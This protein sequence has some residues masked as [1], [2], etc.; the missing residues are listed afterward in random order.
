M[1]QITL[2]LLKLCHYIDYNMMVQMGFM[3]ANWDFDAFV[4]ITKHN[5]SKSI[6]TWWITP[7]N[8]LDQSVMR[9]CKSM[10]SCQKGPT[11]HAYTWQIGPF[12]QDTLEVWNYLPL[13]QCRSVFIARKQE[14]CRMQHKQW[15]CIVSKPIT[16]L[17][18]CDISNFYEI[19]MN[20]HIRYNYPMYP[21][22]FHVYYISIACVYPLPH[23]T[24]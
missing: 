23:L 16:F 1:C 3:I 24:I 13:I 22:D 7:C 6:W 17:H 14:K 9:L 8:R 20:M 19:R 2:M 15:V 21:V 5:H 12:R 4:N 10:V 18:L 11:C